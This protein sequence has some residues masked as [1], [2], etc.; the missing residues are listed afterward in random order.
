[1]RSG[2]YPLGGLQPLLSQIAEAHRL[3][4]DGHTRGKLVVDVRS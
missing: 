3:L 4:E 2:A 1:M